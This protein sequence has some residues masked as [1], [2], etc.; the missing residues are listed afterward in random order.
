MLDIFEFFLDHL[1]VRIMCEHHV[2]M[3][4]QAMPIVG[5]YKIERSK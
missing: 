1:K 2:A 3:P 5:R 4:T